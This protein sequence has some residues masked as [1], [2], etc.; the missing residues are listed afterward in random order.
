MGYKAPNGRLREEGVHEIRRRRDA[1][2]T[3]QAIATSLGLSIGTVFNVVKK[4]T[5]NWLPDKKES[6]K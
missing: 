2:E 6:A 5:W 1:G 3:L 4:K